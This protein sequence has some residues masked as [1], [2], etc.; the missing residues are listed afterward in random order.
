MSRFLT[1]FSVLVCLCHAQPN[2]ISG[3]RIRAHVKYLSSDQMEG[4][5]IGTRGET[6]AT[7]YLAA[8]FAQAGAQPAGDNGT[9]FQTVPLVGVRSLPESSLKAAGPGGRGL[10]LRFGDDIVGV[11][12]R[13]QTDT[14]VDADAIFVGHGIAAPEYQWDDF[15]GVDVRGKV[16]VLFTNEPQSEDPKLF[17]GHALT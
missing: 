10:P 4:R 14:R 11:S 2:A 17:G 8:Q 6:L 7:D 3:E 12:Q 16:I 1:G 15:K 5:G 9:Y 13:Q